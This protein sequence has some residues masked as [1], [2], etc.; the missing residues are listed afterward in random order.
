MGLEAG[1]ISQRGLT[2]Q[3]AVSASRKGLGASGHRA[4]CCGE[5]DQC[6]G[7]GSQLEANAWSGS[8]SSAMFSPD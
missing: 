1:A 6:C 4:F 5:P 8:P 2:D 7:S 3:M